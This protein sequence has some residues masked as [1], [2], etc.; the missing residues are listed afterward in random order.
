MCRNSLF[1]SIQSL[2]FPLL[3][4]ARCILRGSRLRSSFAPGMIKGAGETKNKIPVLCQKLTLP[5]VLSRS[6]LDNLKVKIATLGP[7]EMLLSQFYMV[8][9]V[10]Q[11]PSGKKPAF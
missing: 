10:N 11:S 6:L 8:D 3:S 7:I 5:P 1:T 4:A 9:K 2:V